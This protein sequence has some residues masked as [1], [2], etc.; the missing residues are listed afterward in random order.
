MPDFAVQIAAQPKLRAHFKTPPRKRG[1][2]DYVFLRA[3]HLGPFILSSISTKPQSPPSSCALVAT[4]SCITQVVILPNT[5]HPA[6]SEGITVANQQLH[7]MAEPSLWSH[8]TVE[9]R[10]PLHP[11][12][13]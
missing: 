3:Q 2:F 9:P 13:E 10:P 8:W 5:Q 11:T 6:Q 1:S 4:S 12:L 7:L